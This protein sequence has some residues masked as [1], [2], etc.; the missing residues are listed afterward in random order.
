VKG[1]GATTSV[2]GLGRPARVPETDQL[3]EDLPT[4]PYGPIDRYVD[5]RPARQR[6]RLVFA[7]AALIAVTVVAAVY[8]RFGLTRVVVVNADRLVISSVKS[9]VFDEYVPATARV[10]PRTTAYLDAVEGG[11][12]AEVLVEEG[13]LVHQGQPL[14]RLKN[15]NL[16]LEILGRQAQLMEQL[17]RLNTTILTYEQARLGH[18]RD[19]IEATAQ[20][21]QLSQRLRRRQALQPSGAVSAADIDEVAIDLGRYRKQAAAIEEAAAIDEKFQREQVAQLRAAVKTIQ[22]NLGMAGETLKGLVVKAPIT[23]Q[24]TALD[25]HLGEAKSPGQRIGQIDQLDDYKVE[26][27]IDEFYLGRVAVG[28]TATTEIDGKEY[29]LV[30][31]KAYSQVTDR[32]FKVDLLFAG[33][34][35]RD[36]KRQ[37]RDDS[38]QK[39]GR[40]SDQES[41]QEARPESHGRPRE[42][43]TSALRRGQSLQ[44]RLHIGAAHRA[45]VIANGPF[46]D[47]TGGTWAFVLPPNG[48]EAQPHATRLGRRNPQQIEVLS[49][50]SAGDRLITSSYETLR[51]FDRIR[52]QGLTDRQG[53]LP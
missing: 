49:G 37:L 13:A 27:D 41:D 34:L 9:D 15:T 12:V 52:I 30:L 46:Y 25:A 18:E 29:R 51:G 48:T 19:R 3:G 28:Q 14:V 5:S 47:D 31:A 38:E 20:V 11:Q 33:D 44:I 42:P 24:L 7:A 8:V 21:E 22:E 39:A 4:P 45:L 17:D 50:L 40:K 23:G 32:Q 26:A 2:R 1:S 43:P 35:A 36:P 53:E 6:R 16:Q 10:A